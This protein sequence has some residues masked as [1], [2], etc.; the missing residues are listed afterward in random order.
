MDATF[1]ELLSRAPEPALTQTGLLPNGSLSKV[2]PRFQT[3]WD[4]TS[5]GLFKECNRKYYYSILEQ[6][7]TRV[8]SEHLTFGIAAHK[9]REYYYIDRAAGLT[10]EAA[11]QS[12]AEATLFEAWQCV[13]PDW[14]PLLPESKKKKDL[15]HLLMFLVWYTEHYL[16]DPLTTYILADG[17]PAV[18]LSFKLPT[19]VVTP[20]GEQV[21]LAGHIDR[22]VIYEGQLWI[23]DLKTTGS[24]LGQNY[25][26]QYSPDN[27]M[28]LYY[29]AGKHIFHL[30]IAGIIV[31]AVQLLSDACSFQRGFI[32][33]TDAQLDEWF[34]DLQHHVRLAHSL[35]R[36]RFDTPWPM[37]DKSCGNY[38]GCAFR[39][40]CSQGPSM[41]EAML[42]AHYVRKLWD[43]TINRGR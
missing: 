31:D 30:P 8:Q 12:A 7:T 23:T 27:Q 16:D 35:A 9:A 39:D 43:P 28:S 41:R 32:Y 21:F 34:Q 24:S 20:E 38:G 13:D 3:T 6:W 17:R 10:H 5:L 26:D 4:S 14:L 1:D 19:G 40:V 29:Y 11:L 15:Y 36:G 22:L 33:R 2:L 18:E 25:F 42:Q 37:N